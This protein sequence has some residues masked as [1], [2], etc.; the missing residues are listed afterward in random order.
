M[1][2]VQMVRATVFHV[3]GDV[4]FGE[5]MRFETETDDDAPA[6]IGIVGR[7]ASLAPGY[8]QDFALLKIKCGS[9]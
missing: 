7:N 6:V 9:K 2:N 4:R 1:Q 8:I 3:D 5:W